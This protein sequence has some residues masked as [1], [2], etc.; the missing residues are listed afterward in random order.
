MFQVYYSFL[1]KCIKGP[2]KEIKSR[3]LN[4][5]HLQNDKEFINTYFQIQNT[6][7]LISRKGAGPLNKGQIRVLKSEIIDLFDPF[8]LI[9]YRG[10]NVYLDWCTYTLQRLIFIVRDKGGYMA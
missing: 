5:F 3:P 8:F 6:F 4:F 7:Y 1:L 2:N 10:N 9:H